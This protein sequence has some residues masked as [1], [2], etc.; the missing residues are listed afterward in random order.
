MVVCRAI[1]K[2]HQDAPASRRPCFHRQV[3]GLKHIF[4]EEGAF[5]VGHPRGSLDCIRRQRAIGGKTLQ[6]L[7]AGRKDHHGHLIFPL[8]VAKY[9]QGSLRQGLERSVHRLGHVEEQHYGKRQL[10]AA[11]IADRLRD[12]IFRKLKVVCRQ[13]VQRTSGLLVLYQGIEQDELGVDMDGC[14][15]GLRGRCWRLCPANLRQQQH[16]EE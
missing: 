4:I 3:H 6:Q 11:E 1:R 16:S 7:C 9:F 5:Y 10:I 2:P 14:R 12:T 8:Q 15:R 13:R